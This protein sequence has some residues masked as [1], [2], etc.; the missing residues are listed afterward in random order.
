MASLTLK[1]IYKVY[2]NG[3][4][5]VNDFT[6]DI[7]DKEFIV[8]VGPSGCGKSTVLRMIAGLEEISAGELKIDDAV[9][10]DVDCKMRDTAM[11]FQNYALYPHMT[12]AE[13]MAFPLKMTKL[14]KA[15]KAEL[16]EETDRR[17]PPVVSF[18]ECQKREKKQFLAEIARENGGKLPKKFKLRKDDEQKISLRAKERYAAL[19]LTK[20][21][22]AA[23][24][25]EIK[26]SRPPVPVLTAEDGTQ[27]KER[28]KE[29]YPRS[30]RNGILYPLHKFSVRRELVREKRGEYEVKRMPSRLNNLLRFYHAALVRREHMLAKVEETANI[31]GLEEYLGKRPGAMSGGQRQRVALGRAMVRNPKVFLLDEP[32]SNLDAKLRT[33]MRSEITKLHNRLQTTFIYVT[34][35]QTEAMTMGDRIVVMKKGRIQQ[36]DTPLNLYAYPENV[37][38]A[39]FIGTPAMN[40]FDATVTVEGDNARIVFANGKELTFSADHLHKLERKYLGVSLTFGVRPEDFY[41]SE[42][43]VTCRVT[44]SEMLGSETLLY[45]DF[46]TDNIT[47]YESSPYNFILKTEGVCPHRSGDI[48]KV[49]VNFAKTHYFDKESGES[50]M[51]RFVRYNDIGARAVGGKLSVGGKAADLPPA[52]CLPD[53]EYRLVFPSDAVA[54]GSDYPAEV[55]GCERLKEGWLARLS[56]DGVPFYALFSEEVKGRV[57]VDIRW[58]RVQFIANGKIVKEALSTDDALGVILRKRRLTAAERNKLP[59][60]EPRA[61]DVDVVCG[62]QALVCPYPVLKRLMGA[63]DRKLFG[64]PMQ[65]KFDESAIVAGNRFCAE[66]KRVYDYGKQTYALCRCMD[67][68]VVLP[69]LS[70]G[71][72]TVEFDIDL[73]KASVFDERVGI[74]IT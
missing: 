53:G 31:L 65:L 35:D 20:E 51:K 15:E 49:N 43:G 29:R 3:T 17:Y 39:G 48:V 61:F 8:F 27:I 57:I 46:D 52:I 55:L 62:A 66:V 2:P 54:A 5:A 11:V 7:G 33:Q 36:I 24:K 59:A 70:K 10:N 60:D 1:N 42:E 47:N 18:S 4:K 19:R 71:G 56:V 32:L 25:E 14:T 41:L 58:H 26:N 12:V 30:F 16:R 37:F 9:V 73:T 38:V 74:K 13:N 34:H 67:T 21:Q 22:R 68:D 72:S 69:C 23:L 28:L 40:F 44:N 64:V 6:M 45:C 63:S 50:V